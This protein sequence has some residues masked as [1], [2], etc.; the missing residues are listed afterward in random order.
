[1]KIDFVCCLSG[2]VCLGGS[3]ILLWK[4]KLQGALSIS[5]T[6]INIAAKNWGIEL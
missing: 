6:C 2:Q 4:P 5:C 1:M 3:K